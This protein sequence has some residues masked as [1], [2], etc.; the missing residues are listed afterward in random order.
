[1]LIAGIIFCLDKNINYVNVCV[2]LCFI[3]FILGV[4]YVLYFSLL[5]KLVNKNKINYLNIANVDYEKKI[6]DLMQKIGDL[7]QYKKKLIHNNPKYFN[8]MLKCYDAILKRLQDRNISI[9]E[10]VADIVIFNDSFTYK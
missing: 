6:N 4:C 3:N 5:P 8:K 7:D 9:T 2:S 10:K 1:M